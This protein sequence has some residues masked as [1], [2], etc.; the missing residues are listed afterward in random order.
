MR[1][2]AK[3]KVN[4]WVYADLEIGSNGVLLFKEEI[5]A[6]TCTCSIN[7][8]DEDKKEIFVGDIVIAQRF[9][10]VVR[11]NEN[12]ARYEIYDEKYKIGITLKCNPYTKVLPESEIIG[13]IFE[14][15]LHSDKY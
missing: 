14:N 6:D 15:A 9:K 11:Y 7:M 5:I 1:Y 12:Q 4:E 3:N 8:L 2:R 10:G 13:N